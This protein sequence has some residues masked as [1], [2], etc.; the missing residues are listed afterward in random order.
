MATLALIF[1]NC[2]QMNYQT[3]VL[4]IGGGI[5]GLVTAI[6][7]LDQGDKKILILDRDTEE[8]LGGLARESFGGIFIVDSPEQRRAK[9]RDSH[10]L[11]FEDWCSMAGFTDAD[12][13]SRAW[14]KKY[15]SETRTGIYDWLKARGVKF[16]PVVHWIERGLFKPGNSVPRFHMV[17]G[18]GKGLIDHL[19]DTIARHPH[20]A[21]LT[22]HFEHHVKNLTKEGSRIVGCEG[23]QRD[24]KSFQAKASRTVVAAGGI[25]GDVDLV[26]KNWHPDFGSS[27]PE[28]LLNGAHRY[29]DGTLHRAVQAIGGNVIHLNRQWNYAAGVHHPKSNRPNHGLSIVPPKSALWMNYQ[30]ERIGPVPLITSYDTRFL[31]EE[32]CKQDR[33]YSWQILNMKIAKK[34]L[35][36]SG[37]DYNDSIRDKKLFSFLKDILFGNQKLVN[38][39]TST[40][41]DFVV[42][43]SLEELGKKMNALNGDEAVSLDLIRR[44]IEKYDATIDRG[45]KYFNDE[46][47]RR[48]MAARKYR[49][50]RVRTCK[51][52]KI[53]D[54]SAG[55]LIA[56]REFILARKTLGGVQTDFDSRV[57]DSNMKPV[58]GLYAVGESA[59]Y[60]GGNLHG[61][62][63]LE[64]TF[65]GGCIVSAHAA[66]NGIQKGL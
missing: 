2:I 17:W 28:T 40:C 26:K 20:R 37:S 36:V 13:H 38:D 48:I 41:K 62:S 60:G 9:I 34:E 24:Q 57:L 10:E 53:L 50:D 30:G 6:D 64:G 35:A 22:I 11:A 33:K 27:P 3:D 55:P 46:Q 54:P 42:A 44:D 19:K 56:I 8:R 14:A 39:L 43:P 52:Q 12:A 51:Y 32:I 59:G 63:C 25:C 21:N 29:G 31:V 58:E 15:I 7:L 1:Y 45:E 4:I 66:S 47:L 18:T 5:A 49:G 61:L 23:V 16:F 65:L